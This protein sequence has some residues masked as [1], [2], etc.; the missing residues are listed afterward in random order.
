MKI[1]MGQLKQKHL[2]MMSK[3][4]IDIN[5]IDK[6]MLLSKM[7]VSHQILIMRK[8]NRIK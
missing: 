8:M 2:I 3:S 1:M 7:R 4:F 6:S 5:Y